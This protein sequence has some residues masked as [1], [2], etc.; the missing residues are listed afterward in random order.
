MAVG[1]AGNDILQPEACK[2]IKNLYTM[3]VENNSEVH[4][5]MEA[6]CIEMN[7]EY[8]TLPA[9][10]PPNTHPLPTTNPATP[11]HDANAHQ[12]LGRAAQNSRTNPGE[13]QERLRRQP[14]THP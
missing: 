6:W 4:A 13:D 2:N 5:F 3:M 7:G 12:V 14:T 1:W 11:R 8:V 9:N 10:P